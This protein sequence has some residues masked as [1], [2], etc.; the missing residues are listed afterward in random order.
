MNDDDEYTVKILQTANKLKSRKNLL[1]RNI[2]H[3][4]ISGMEEEKEIDDLNINHTDQF[5]WR[6]R[7]PVT[8]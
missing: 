5:A 6:N 4:R 2:C 3:S 1:P 8:C 7:T